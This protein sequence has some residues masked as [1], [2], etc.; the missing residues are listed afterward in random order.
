[1]PHIFPKV[2]SLW[3]TAINNRA[4]QI[5]ALVFL[6]GF[7]AVLVYLFHD[8]ENLKR[9]LPYGYLGVFLVELISCATIIIP[10]PGT[11]VVWLAGGTM[12]PFLWAG[13]W[14]GV[15]ASIG[16]TLGELTSYLLGYW[17]QGTV[18]IGQRK[19]YQRAERWM[20]RY[21]SS[22]VFIFALLP[23][24]IDLVGIASGALR[25]PL[26][27]FILACWAGKLPKCILIA[28]LGSIS[29]KLFFPGLF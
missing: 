3:I 18:K 16:G 1:L 21:G 9:F 14:V 28:Y 23:L 12:L 8:I 6:L 17:G 22:I 11:L 29:V 13:V 5:A 10:V 4:V 24:P 20:K 7:M 19:W 25:F 26:W 2:R 15:V 27:K